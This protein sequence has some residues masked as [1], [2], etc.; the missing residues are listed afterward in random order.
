MRLQGKVAVITGVSGDRQIGQ[1][2]AQALAKEGAK[3]VLVARR[4][5]KVNARTDEVKALGA[6]AL[7]SCSWHPTKPV[8]SLV[9]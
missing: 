6:E 4:A 7:R 8:A 3:L 1:A 9:K 5:D 2:V